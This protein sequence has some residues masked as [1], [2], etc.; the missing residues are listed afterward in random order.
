M[1]EAITDSSNQAPPAGLI[2]LRR[3][4]DGSSSITRQAAINNKQHLDRIARDPRFSHFTRIPARIIRCL[5]HFHIQCDRIAAGRILRAYYIFIAVVDSA[6]DSG[7]SQ[8]ADI[9]FEH[10]ANPIPPNQPELSDV[11]LITQHLRLQLDESV[12]LKFQHQ[13]RWLHETVR[14]ERNAVSIEAYVD[15]RRA[16]G[17]LTADLSYLLI[18]PLFEVEASDLRTFMQQV[19]SVGCLIDS[20]IDLRA[21]QRHG[22]VS[23]T[24]TRRAYIKLTLAALREGLSIGVRH[25]RL[26]GLFTQAILDNLRD[27]FIASSASMI[28]R[29]EQVRIR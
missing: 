17:Q 6:I 8:T 19:G 14:Q 11:A 25:P 5:D 21:D 16:V 10:L 18:S 22:L 12:S 29:Q 7:E 24:P 1:F 13:L 20:M 9:V 2:Q 3:R 4:T 15:V 27:R 28:G 23:F 26:V